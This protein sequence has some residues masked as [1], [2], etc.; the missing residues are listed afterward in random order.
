[1]T[2]YSIIMHDPQPLLKGW[3]KIVVYVRAQSPEAAM[4][5]SRRIFGSKYIPERATK[6]ISE[7]ERAYWRRTWIKAY[8]NMPMFLMRN[9]YTVWQEQA[10]GATPL[11]AF[12]KAQAKGKMQLRGKHHIFKKKVITKTLRSSKL[13]NLSRLLNYRRHTQWGVAISVQRGMAFGTKPRDPDKRELLLKLSSPQ[14][15]QIALKLLSNHISGELG[16]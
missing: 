4:K 13:L 3:D 11:P 12:I 15:Q 7:Q 6:I 1:M 16:S 10:P 8:Y 5:A 2:T 14:G 9:T